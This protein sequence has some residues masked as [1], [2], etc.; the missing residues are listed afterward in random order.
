MITVRLGYDRFSNGANTVQLSIVL[1]RWY[2]IEG[3][4]YSD[5]FSEWMG[6]LDKGYCT[7]INLSLRFVSPRGLY[8]SNIR[9]RRNH[10]QVRG[11][12]REG[13]E[14]RGLESVRERK[15]QLSWLEVIPRR[16]E[17]VRERW[18]WLEKRSAMTLTFC[19]YPN[20]LLSF[21]KFHLRNRNHETQLCQVAFNNQS[22]ECWLATL[23]CFRVWTI[24]DL[25]VIV[26]W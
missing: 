9:R 10:S 19:L 3:I 4:R 25:L 26:N 5:G 8:S 7:I 1:M 12:R 23:D 22:L 13:S 17:M 21:R 16:L 24:I 14:S 20:S 2:N 18:E 11:G 15:T 6:T